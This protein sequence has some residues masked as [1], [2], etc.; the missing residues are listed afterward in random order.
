MKILF[1]NKTIGFRLFF[2]ISIIGIG[3]FVFFPLYWMVNTSIKP[4]EG[5][6]NLEFFP[7]NPT[8]SNYKNVL[9]DIKIIGYM[10]NSLFVALL[11]SFFSTLVAALAGYSI[12]K[13]R[14][15]GR[16]EI[17]LLFMSSKMF[18]QALL[19]LTIYMTISYIGLRDSYL[20]LIMAFVTFTL[21]VGTWSLK[22][23][24]DKIPDELIESA[25]ID[26]SSHMN[27]IV[28]IILPLAIPGL[29][30]VA[31]YGFIW[32]WNDVLYS[33]TLITSP[34]K[35]TL[36]PG[37]ILS[38]MGEFQSNWGNM[39]TASIVASI[40]VALLFILSQKF[41]I[42]GLTAGAVKG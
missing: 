11:S 37:L 18:P 7:K 41:F 15:K 12:S 6:L 17:M 26:G 2:W 21:P 25:K 30:S 36:A 35:R 8:L 20:S 22:C 10:K 31:I 38:Y 29:I 28:K 16:K 27:T 34:D 19:L 23:Y 24:F 5:I 32:G 13:F 4:S 3:L 1:S 33:L 40:P 9:T 42:E 14:Y 39:M